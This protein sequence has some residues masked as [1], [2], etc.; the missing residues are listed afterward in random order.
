[1]PRGIGIAGLQRSSQTKAR[2]QEKG[3]ELAADELQHMVKQMNIFKQNL[4][5]FA[6]KHKKDLKKNPEFRA[7][8]QQ[9]CAQV[10]V[11]PLASSKGFWAQTLGVG[12]FY[13]ELGVQIIEI[14]IAT[15]PMNGGLI[16]ID[17]L[18]TRVNKTRKSDNQVSND[19]IIRAIGK[20]KKLGS[21]FA[22]IPINNSHF[23]QSVPG[24]LNMDHTTLLALAE[25]NHGQITLSY[26]GTCSL[27]WQPER[28]ERALDY[29][30]REELAW[31]D[32]Q[33]SEVSYWFPN[34][35]NANFSQ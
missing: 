8:F 24:E 10:G 26:L 15:R 16:Q 18:R 2:F 11:D 19:D 12:D 23:I 33:G 4:E 22:V 29:L 14:C 7:F 17:D 32:N 34:L 1:M 6:V 9:M 21:G 28:I 35:F 13:Y 5:E 3:A 25:K 31:V 20:L 30:L 27:N